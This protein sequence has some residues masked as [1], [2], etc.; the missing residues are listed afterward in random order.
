MV[1]DLTRQLLDVEQLDTLL[2]LAEELKIKDKILGLFDGTILNMS[3]ERSVLHSVLRA[4]KDSNVVVNNEDVCKQVHHVLD[5]IETFSNDVR[6]GKIVS[7]DGKTF[8]TLLCIGIGGSFLGTAF[9]SDAFMGNK[10]AR[11]AAAGKSIR[12]LS[13]VD[14]AAFRISTKGLDAKRTLVIIISKTFTTTETMKNAQAAKKWLMENIEDTDS[15]GKFFSIKI[16]ISGKHLCAVSTNLKLTKEFG[17]DDDRGGRFSVCSAVGMLPLSLYFGFEIA[18]EF[19][20]GCHAMDTHFKTAEFRENLPVLMGLASFYNAIILEFNTVAVLPYSQDLGRFPNYVQQL[21]MES[22]GKSVDEN[23]AELKYNAGEIF[24]GESGTNGQHSF[25]QLLHQGRTVPAEFIGF[26]KNENPD[27]ATD[28]VT[29][30]E[31]LMANFFAQPDALAY[32]ISEEQLRA[33]GCK[34]ALVPHKNSY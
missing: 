27:F 12:F 13:N 5:R 18:K 17:I 31:E 22:N 21:A 30:H 4:P 6:S 8:N 23:G 29:F 32:G 11:L 7:S 1:L 33:K 20:Q 24:F 3:E 26:I 28:G 9:T 19:L 15:V 25:Y 10:K 16:H 2:A 34:D 14:P